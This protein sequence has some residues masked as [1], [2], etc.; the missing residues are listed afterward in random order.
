MVHQLQYMRRIYDLSAA[1]LLKVNYEIFAGILR[2][3]KLL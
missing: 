2:G 1:G 3:C